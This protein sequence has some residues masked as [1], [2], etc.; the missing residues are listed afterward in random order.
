M[1]DFE[2]ELRSLEEELLD[3][4]FRKNR[5]M[6]TAILTED[7]CEFGSSGQVFNKESILEALASE[8]PKKIS[9]VDFQVKSLTKD[10]AL[11]TYRARSEDAQGQ[12]TMTLRS[13]VWVRREKSW[14]ILFHQGTK[15]AI[16]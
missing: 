6:V 15:V 11:V 1:A 5:E 9:I 14:Q 7:F 12:S 10:I 16:V 13:S 3:P 2:M 4:A 8:L